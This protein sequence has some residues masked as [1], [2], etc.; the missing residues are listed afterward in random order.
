MLRAK[1][2]RVLASCRSSPRH[3]GSL[4]HHAELVELRAET[5]P[6]DAI[7]YLRGFVEEALRVANR[8]GL[9]RLRALVG[10]AAK[11]SRAGRHVESLHGVRSQVAQANSR[12]P[13][14]LDELRKARLV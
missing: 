1:T 6:A 3:P 14:F 9:P 13:A 4:R 11:C 12:R 10:R 8:E 7:P 2:G 5:H